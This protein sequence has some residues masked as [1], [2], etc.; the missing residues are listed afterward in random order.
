MTMT[1]KICRVQG[2]TE[3]VAC[4]GVT[5]LVYTVQIGNFK[6]TFKYCKG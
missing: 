5:I 4:Y 6:I 1:I 3:S 2:V